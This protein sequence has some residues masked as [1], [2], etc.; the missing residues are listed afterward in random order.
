[1]PSFELTWD[2]CSGV[3]GGFGVVG[4][5]PPAGVQ[6]RSRARAVRSPSV[7]RTFYCSRFFAAAPRAASL[8]HLLVYRLLPV[9]LRFSLRSLSR[10]LEIHSPSLATGMIVRG[11]VERFANPLL[12]AADCVPRHLS[13][14]TFTIAPFL[15]PYNPPILLFPPFI[16][17]PLPRDTE[18][19]KV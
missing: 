7:T 14:T 13:T 5:E 1:M 16:F 4:S 2:L 19:G 18:L 10:V 11:E 8:V 15:R 6:C 17:F 9:G 3:D 12:R